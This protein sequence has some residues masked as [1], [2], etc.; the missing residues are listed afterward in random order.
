[1]I[2]LQYGETSSGVS[3]YFSVSGMDCG[4]AHMLLL[5]KQQHSYNIL[6]QYHSPTSLPLPTSKI[7]AQIPSPRSNRLNKPTRTACKQHWRLSRSSAKCQCM[8]CFAGT[9]NTAEATTARQLR[10]AVKTLGQMPIH[11]HASQEQGTSMEP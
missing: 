2:P 1:V 10:P 4:L 5:A 7:T 3:V 11:A 6:S 9:R 8:P